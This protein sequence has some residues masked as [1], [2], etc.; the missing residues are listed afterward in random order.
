MTYYELR[1]QC[2][3]QWGRSASVTALARFWTDHL[4]T[5]QDSEFNHEATLVPVVYVAGG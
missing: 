3:Q 1:C 4:D 2:G 5:V